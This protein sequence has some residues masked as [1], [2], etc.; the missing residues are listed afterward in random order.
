MDVVEVAIEMLSMLLDVV[1]PAVVGLEVEEAVVVLVATARSVEEEVDAFSRKISASHRVI[2][3]QEEVTLAIA[4]GAQ[5][6]EIEGALICRI[7]V[8]GLLVGDFAIATFVIEVTRAI[9]TAVFQPGIRVWVLI[10]SDEAIRF[11]PDKVT[12]LVRP[13]IEEV[14]LEIDPAIARKMSERAT[15]NVEAAQN[16]RVRPVDLIQKPSVTCY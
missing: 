12:L 3:N 5:R 10:E 4:R 9:V 1:A 16:V 2:A 14:T 11:Y 8:A 13:K 6:A 15:K 7:Q